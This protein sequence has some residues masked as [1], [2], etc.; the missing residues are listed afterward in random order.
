MQ[1]LSCLL[2]RLTFDLTSGYGLVLSIL[3]ENIGQEFVVPTYKNK[4]CLDRYATGN[5]HE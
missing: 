5:D 2:G 3:G 1:R 4:F